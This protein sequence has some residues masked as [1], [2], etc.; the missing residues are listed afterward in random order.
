MVFHWSL[1]KNTSPQISKTFLSS[2]AYLKNAVFWMFLI[3]PLISTPPNRSSICLKTVPKAQSTVS[4]SLSYS[5][6]FSLTSKIIILLLLF[7]LFEVFPPA[8]VDVF[9]L[10]F[11]WQKVS[12]CSRTFLSIL[13]DL[14][15]A[16]VWMI[17]T[18]PLI[19]KSS[20]SYHNPLVTIPRA[21]ITNRI[22]V[23]FMFYRVF[24]NDAQVFKEVFFLR[25]FNHWESVICT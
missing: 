21:P 17:S 4:S 15:N 18:R 23:T 8:L 2:V 25:A 1:S 14:N 16:V 3:L 5:A 12:K 20:S 22:T 13:T 7:L 24:F 11:K 10:D 19:S 6:V 9:S